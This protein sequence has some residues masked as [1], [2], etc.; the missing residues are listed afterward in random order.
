L[1]NL[2]RASDIKLNRKDEL[3]RR[4]DELTGPL[5]WDGAVN[6]LPQGSAASSLVA[7]MVFAHVLRSARL[8]A[9][10]LL[11]N[12]ADNLVVVGTTAKGVERAERTLRTCFCNSP[13]GHLH[14]RCDATGRIVEGFDW[15]GFHFERRRGLTTYRPSE[16]NLRGLEKDTQELLGETRHCADR[17]M[18]AEHRR[19]HLQLKV[20]GWAESFTVS[21]QRELI[22]DGYGPAAA[23][24]AD[25]YLSETEDEVRRTIWDILRELER[26]F[27]RHLRGATLI[28]DALK[29]AQRAAR[30]RLRSSPADART[31][32]G[33]PRRGIYVPSPHLL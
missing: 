26:R 19:R 5:A 25:L 10:V 1:T 29:A 20:A 16:K 30:A 4:S 21:R 31:T 17:R 6:S 14:L 24:L 9:N 27:Q 7:A 8:P 33:R 18:R 23:I 12:W 3:N 11:V 13:V 32:S 15:L 28:D 2:H 22:L